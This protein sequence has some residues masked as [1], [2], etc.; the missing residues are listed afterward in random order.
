MR[1]AH[2]PRS[3]CA[4]HHMRL[5]ST[6]PYA[7]LHHMRLAHSVFH[8]PLAPDAPGFHTPWGAFLLGA[9]LHHGKEPP[10]RPFAAACPHSC[11]S[12]PPSLPPALPPSLPPSLQR[13]RLR[14]WLTGGGTLLLV[15]STALVFYAEC[16]MIDQVCLPLIAPGMSPRMFPLIA[17]VWSTDH[18]CLP[19][20]A[21]THC[22]S[23]F[24]W[25]TT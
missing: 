6:H 7:P 12:L 11:L 3:I 18:V 23:S 4:M 13:S 22:H 10:S 1:L 17:H 20:I 5:G 9:A 14:T 8:M 15:L 25:S 2:T 19:L 16:P 24:S 21:P